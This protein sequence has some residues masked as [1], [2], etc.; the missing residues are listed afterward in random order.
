METIQSNSSALTKEENARLIIDFFHRLMMHHAMWFTEVQHQLGTEKAFEAL[1]T[2][3]EK[4]S[5][6]QMTRLAKTL[7]FELENG[8]PKPLLD[9]PEG[10][11][12][13]LRESMASQL[14]GYRRR[15]VSGCGV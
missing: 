6:I 8:L 2:A 13:K 12:D 14:A 15:V 5:S 10:S 11:L 1:E 9:L 3:W 7:G 4:T